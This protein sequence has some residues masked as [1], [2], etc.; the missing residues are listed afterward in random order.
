MRRR[1]GPGRLGASRRR[2]SVQRN[3]RRTARHRRRRR[4]RRVLLVGGLVA[5]GAYKMSKRDAKRIEE[6]TGIAPEEMT[7][8]E[9]EQAMDDLQI[10]KQY[11]DERDREFAVEPST[12]ESG[13]PAYMDEL[14][15]L[16][17]LRDQGVITEEEFE[18]KKKQLLG[19]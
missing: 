10:E 3:R 19:I 18:A 16:A 8:Q 17:E 14:K 13:S 11:R 7:D 5:F 2:R 4:R 12:P 1:P 9:L 15:R 6:H